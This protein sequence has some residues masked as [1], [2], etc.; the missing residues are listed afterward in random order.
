MIRRNSTMNQ[1]KLSA[2]TFEKLEFNKVIDRVLA[3][4]E[5]IPA[6]EYLLNEPWL[7]DKSSIVDALT[8][9]SEYKKAS[10]N[11]IHWDIIPYEPIGE[12]LSLLRKEGYVLDIVE[13]LNIRKVLINYRYFYNTFN[14]GRKKE[15]PFLY[16]YLQ[17]E[18][19]TDKPLISIER[20]F[21]ETG[22]VKINASPQLLR[23]FKKEEALI[24]Q[25]EKLFGEVLKRFKNANL[26]SES[27]E[28]IRNGRRVL[29]IPTEKK[30]QVEGVIHDESASGKLLYIE[31]SELM[32]LNNELFSIEHE[33]R[34][35]I[36]RILSGLCD[37]L[38]EYSD[39]LSLLYSS[40][41]RMD[42][43][44][45]KSRFS[46]SIDGVFP[47]ISQEPI[48]KLREVRH[49]LLYIQNIESGKSTVPFD[50]ELHGAN[51]M[52]LISGPN[53]GGKSVT[54]KATGLVHLML[55]RGLL[56]PVRSDS[57]MG[58][59]D[60]IFADIGDHQS[61]DE[62]LSTFSSHL[63]NLKEVVANV[64]SRS[65][66]L[67]D[68]IGS[69]TDPNAG[70]AIAEGVILK[71]L[72]EKAF[73]ILTTHFSSLKLFVFKQK[74]I[75][76]GAM[77]FDKENLAPMY[78]LRVGKPGSSYAFEVAG[79]VGLDKEI[80]NHAR[81][82]I[83]KKEN[84]VEDLLIDLQEDRAI[85]DEQLNYIREEKIRL[86][87]LIR[88][89]EELNKDFQVKR[90][91]LLMQTKELEYQKV[92]QKTEELKK[93]LK[94]L[95][96]EKDIVKVKE[97]YKQTEKQRHD[98]T[99]QI[100]MLREEIVNKQDDKVEVKVGDYVKM[101]EG[102]MN[103]EVL[104]ISGKNLEV[105]F[106]LIRMT[107]K[108][109]EVYRIDKPLEV[110]QSRRINLKGVAYESNFSPKLDIRGYTAQQAEET[111]Q[112]FFDK[113]LLNNARLLEVVHGKGSGILRK[114]LLRKMK[115]YKDIN[116]Y[117]HPDEHQGGDT[118]TVIKI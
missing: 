44:V 11:Q 41:I 95:E 13:V 91:K 74:G 39:T 111:L 117:W 21:D 61:I 69:G 34:A 73:G 70:N 84:Q 88:S 66:V 115:E 23:L 57:E 51:R 22:A 106:G 14:K 112:D 107:I 108:R 55:Y 85:L 101:Y 103:G 52:V 60:S 42:V 12:A 96:K 20:V 1:L 35:E 54:L 97:L 18:Q 118:V 104:S 37:E 7:L 30:R 9:L 94:Q 62:G 4:C 59:F 92:N 109:K 26:V 3:Y 36:R 24:R 77:L 63:T 49:P 100:I 98:R 38:R 53:A 86:D 116:S 90:K 93:L 6:Q 79:Q 33:K 50:L 89:Y 28:S 83:G 67:L 113:A 58:I 25:Q 19:Y 65:L 87:K 27:G 75:V 72:K 47:S 76:N 16:E 99:D 29:V 78:K 40:V 81:A 64:G 48:L 15:Y 5:G 43:L 105:L 8:R 56:V 17:V 80:I 68:E 82:K 10:E 110:F 45:A 32:I 31:P 2:K 102:D 114:V 71:L 46:M